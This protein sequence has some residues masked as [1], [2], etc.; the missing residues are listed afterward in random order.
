L[1]EFPVRIKQA[2]E[3]RPTVSFVASRMDVG[4]EFR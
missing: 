4:R 1:R 3:A 2:G